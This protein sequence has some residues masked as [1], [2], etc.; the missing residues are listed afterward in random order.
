MEKT[1]NQ[2]L[3]R[4]ALSKKEILFTVEVSVPSDEPESS[5]KKLDRALDDLAGKVEALGYTN[6]D[7]EFVETPYETNRGQLYAKGGFVGPSPFGQESRAPEDESCYSFSVLEDNDTGDFVI[8]VKHESALIA[9]Y[10][11]SE[12]GLDLIDGELPHV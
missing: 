12:S 11:I 9:L 3:K 6:F 8:E 2:D 5:D 10:K 4:P 7:F 1:R